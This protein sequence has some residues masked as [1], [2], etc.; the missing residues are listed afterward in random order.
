MRGTPLA[1]LLSSLCKSFYSPRT[2]TYAA[3]PGFVANK[4][5]YLPA[6]IR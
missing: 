2:V 3:L 4:I 6:P 5:T 1:V